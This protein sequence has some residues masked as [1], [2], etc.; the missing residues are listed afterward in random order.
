MTGSLV[1][2]WRTWR[3]KSREDRLERLALQLERRGGDHTGAPIAGGY[4]FKLFAVAVL[5]AIGVAAVLIMRM[6]YGS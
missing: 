1:T 6:A 3:A 2:R 4:G 5:V